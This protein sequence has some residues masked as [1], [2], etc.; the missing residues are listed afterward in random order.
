MS[1]NFAFIA[2]LLM[3]LAYIVGIIL[4]WELCSHVRDRKKDT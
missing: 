3:L 4:G 1:A 2:V